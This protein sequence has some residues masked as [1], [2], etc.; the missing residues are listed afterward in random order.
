[1]PAG[2]RLIVGL[3]NPGP[4]YRNTRHNLGFMVI[5]RLVARLGANHPKLRCQALLY[6]TGYAGQRLFLAK[7]LTF[8]NESGKAVRCLLAEERIAFDDLLVVYDDLDLPPGCL[9][10][11]RT[12]SSGGHRGVW[13]IIR[14]VGS[15]DFARVR[16]GIGRPEEGQDVVDYVLA[17]IPPGENEFYANAVA[18][19]A[20]ACLIWADSGIDKAMSEYNSVK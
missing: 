1:M 4:R 15:R 16:I 17:S 5:D 11:R 18:K 10:L 9:R 2:P 6:E 3:G 13:S 19:A 20:S 8:M 12:G 14:C 7:P